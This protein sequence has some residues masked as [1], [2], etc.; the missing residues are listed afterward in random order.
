MSVFRRRQKRGPSGGGGDGE[1]AGFVVALGLASLQRGDVDR[2]LEC[3][4]LASRTDDPGV[5]CDL[6]EIYAAMGDILRAQRCLLRAAQGGSAGALR[7]LDALP[8]IA[9]RGEQQTRRAGQDPPDPAADAERLRDAYKRTGDP[10]MLRLAIE[11]ARQ[12][13]AAH[14]TE[15]PGRAAALASL[16]VLLRLDYERGGDKGRLAESVEAGRA[17]VAAGS[18][19]DPGYPPALSSL[20]NALQEQFKVGNDPALLE[21]AARLY[22]TAIELLPPDHPELT[23]LLSNLGNA[24]LAQATHGRDAALLDEAI[25]AGRAALQAGGTGRPASPVQ[26]ANLG[27]ALF[28]RFEHSLSIVDLQEAVDLLSQALAAFPAGYVGRGAVETNRRLASDM[29][30]RAQSGGGPPEPPQA[31]AEGDAD[32]GARAEADVDRAGSLLAMYER[33]GDRPR[34]TESI[35]LLRS[36][37][38]RDG[39]SPRTHQAALH[40]LGTALWSLFERA[41][42]PGTLDESAALL[43]SAMEI[44]GAPAE[45]RLSSKANLSRV[46]TLRSQYSGLETDLQRSIEL[47]REVL[48]E[49]PETGPW[50]AGRM[51]ALATG[52][53]ML[54]GELSDSRLVEEAITVQRA[55]LAAKPRD[56][57]DRAASCSNL[58]MYL[59]TRSVVA[60][61]PADL[62]EAAALCRAAVVATAPG[63]LLLPR[64]QANLGYALLA[65]YRAGRGESDL[66]EA[67]AAARS[68]VAGTPGGHPNRTERHLLF[69]EILEARYVNQPGPARLDELVRA[70]DAAAAATA[71]GH[72]QWAVTATLLAR[73]HALRAL[74]NDNAAGLSVAIDEFRAVA[75]SNEAAIS[76]RIAAAERWAACELAAGN[77]TAA[78]SPLIL[79]VGLLPRAARPSLTRADREQPLALFA[80]L[81]ST[82][83]AVALASGQ[84]NAALRLLEHG[85]GVLLRQALDARGDLTA[86]REAHPDLAAELERLRDRLDPAPGAAGTAPVPA[87]PPSVAA[88]GSDAQQRHAL[89]DRWNAVVAEIRKRPGFENFFQPPGLAELFARCAAGPVVIVNVS[90]LRCDALILRTGGMSVVPLAGLTLKEATARAEAFR[91]DVLAA[92]RPGAAAG[93]V[94]A[95]LGWLW[96]AVAGPVL[97]AIGFGPVIDGGPPPRVWWVP[98]GPLAF[99]PLHAAG[100]HDETGDAAGRN[101]FDRAVSSYLPTAASLP[102]PR[103]AGAAATTDTAAP[104]VLVVAMPSTPSERDLEC[105]QD[106][107]DDIAGRLAGVDVLTGS[108]A[109]RAAV[110]AALPAHPWAHFACHAASS[111]DD[112]S[113]AR[114]LLTDHEDHPL[115]VREIAG[116][117]IPRAELAYL[118]ACDTAR[119]PVQLADEAVHITGAFHMAGYAHVIGTLWSVDDEIAAEVA[120]DV[121][122]RLAAPGPD[123]ARAALALHHAVRKVRERQPGLPALWAAH[124]HVGP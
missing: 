85:R 5:L 110:L 103:E 94:A 19:S 55:V 47:C 35:E 107:A 45:A 123:A 105:A 92:W 56:D 18:P 66:D 96:D 97:D 65:G 10:E 23:G 17:A 9:A 75:T 52:L 95:T 111:A 49:T 115:T 89:A 34:L 33:N 67:A 76:I 91:A 73:T 6:G 21:E 109:T 108:E 4:E 32:T 100:Q 54:G 42:E 88:A 2:A 24:L 101:V 1:R 48:A 71:A 41:G 112:A 13:V 15:G 25:V 81:A 116:L 70:A 51:A 59:L 69:A 63:H 99:L 122:A 38:T 53:H 72:R 68:A 64:F 43:E 8:G 93:R 62:D 82:G 7:V 90:E 11:A 14:R 77:V 83:A 30:R 124:V 40:H 12:G 120:R 87:D 79:A 16:G 113:A 57:P 58:G 98:T 22:R 27:S 3:F 29:L 46:L 37:L 104:G 106:E 119:G 78:V 118:S 114:L 74:V 80:G 31:H 20:G 50:R 36:V 121:Y 117:R 86:L 39:L 60:Q 84:E 44:R 28:W 61:D 102:A 26:Q